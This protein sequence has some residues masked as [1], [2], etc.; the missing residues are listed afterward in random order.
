MPEKQLPAWASMLMLAASGGGV[1]Y[2]Q[3]IAQERRQFRWR[4]LAVRLFIAGFA[5][6]M[7]SL[8]GMALGISPDW[9]D[10]A[11]GMA[12]YLGTEVLNAIKTLVYLRYGMA[13][14]EAISG[15]KNEKGG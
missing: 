1:A 5:G 8:L 11:V 9:H 10:V 12:G 13:Q 7:M 14:R 15:D 3:Q 4:D 2:L 6:Q